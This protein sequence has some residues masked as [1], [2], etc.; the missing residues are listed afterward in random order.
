LRLLHHA[1][2]IRQARAVR[3]AFDEVDAGAKPKKS[4]RK[5]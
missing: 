4:K 1:S 2:L 3:P 5:K